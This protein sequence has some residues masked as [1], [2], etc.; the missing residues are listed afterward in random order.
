MKDGEPWFVAKDVCSALE[1]QNGRDTLN[2]CLDGDEKGVD[3]VYTLGGDQESTII[4]ESGLYRIYSRPHASPLK[5][6]KI[7]LYGYY[8]KR[9]CKLPPCVWGGVNLLYFRFFRLK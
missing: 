1:I 4:N 3:I 2:K 5:I 8:V 6:L 9:T 7:F